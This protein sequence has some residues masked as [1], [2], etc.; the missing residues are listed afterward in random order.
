[1][2]NIFASLVLVL[3]L[4]LSTPAQEASSAPSQAT[5]TAE[6]ARRLDNLE[7]NNRGQ[8]GHL[9]RAGGIKVVT[10]ILGIGAAALLSVPL[11]PASIAVA[12]GFIWGVYEMVAAQMDKKDCPDVN[13]APAAC[14]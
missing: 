10:S 8:W 5:S 14:K 3:C 1:M 6:L 7:A 13:G 12:P 2:R 9:Q 4:S 11:T